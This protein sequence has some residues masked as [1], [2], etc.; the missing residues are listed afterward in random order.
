[1]NKNLNNILEITDLKDMLRKTKEVYGDKEAYKIRDI[2]N[3]DE[4]NKVYKTFTHSE[5]RDMI[6]YL[7]TKLIDLG[8]KD[9]RIAVIGEN[10]YEWQIAYLSAVCGTGTVVPFDNET[11]DM[12]PSNIKYT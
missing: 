5:A 7:G 10:R 12:L 1:M 11:F 4:N 9:K 3:S 2:E 6:D 8:L